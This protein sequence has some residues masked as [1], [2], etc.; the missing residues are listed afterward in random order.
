MA[1]EATTIELHGSPAGNPIR[2][3]CAD[4]V[5]IEK[6]AV[7]WFYNPKT[8][9]GAALLNKP[10]AGIANSE[11]VASDGSTT[12]GVY[13]KGIFTMRADEA[14]TAG[15]LVELS[16]NNIIRGLVGVANIS[17]GCVLGKALETFAAG[18]TKQVLI[19]GTF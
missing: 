5:G 18:E 19:G 9:S 13:T 11:K 15:Q 4:A 7:L 10:F 12:I 16:G 17:G 14:I 1:N 2:F 8:I 3:T 6:G